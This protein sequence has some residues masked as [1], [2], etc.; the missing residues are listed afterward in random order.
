M[1]WFDRCIVATLDQD[2]AS[3]CGP[4]RESKNTRRSAQPWLC[5]Q[6]LAVPMHEKKSCVIKQMPIE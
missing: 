4:R 3:K 1:F 5:A 2:I 6:P